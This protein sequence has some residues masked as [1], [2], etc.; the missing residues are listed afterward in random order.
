MEPFADGFIYHM[1]WNL[2]KTI[3]NCPNLPENVV[4][5][6]RYENNIYWKEYRRL[7]IEIDIRSYTDWERESNKTKIIENYKQ[8]LLLQQINCTL[9]PSPL[10]HGYVTSDDV[11]LLDGE[12]ELWWT[13]LTVLSDCY[14]NLGM[15]ECA[16]TALEIQNKI[17]LNS[18][19]KNLDINS[20]IL[21]LYYKLE[22]IE[23]SEDFEI[24]GLDLWEYIKNT[25]RIIHQF[26]RDNLS[27][28]TL[29][30]EY[31]KAYLE[32]EKNMKKDPGIVKRK[33]NDIFQFLT[34]GNCVF[35]FRD[36]KWKSKKEHKSESIWMKFDNK[37]LEKFHSVNEARVQMYAHNF[38][39]EPMDDIVSNSDI[40][41]NFHYCKDVLKY[42]EDLKY[43]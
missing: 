28:L 11:D 42:F 35:I 27:E 34:L 32:A 10:M 17:S 33:F 20:K 18:A 36:Q 1:P 37:I 25:E 39:E 38:E 15:L 14:E 16:I 43:V 29:K 9:F 4:N 26:L 40:V 41:K 22:N 5:D 21:R 12:K 2:D 23:S 3:H 19:N 7:A 13:N 31:E 6:E 30:N 8:Q 24:T